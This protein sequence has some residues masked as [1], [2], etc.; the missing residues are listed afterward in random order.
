[1]N[2]LLWVLAALL[3][4]VFAAAGGMKLLASR[5]RLMS[6][7]MGYV[8]DF[9][10]GT[11]KTIGVLELLAAVALVAPPLVG[12]APWLTPLAALGLVLLMVGAVLTHRRRHE[13]WLVPAVLGLLALVV[14]WGRSVPAP[15]TGS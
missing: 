6:A 8:E 13:P 11:I 4:C 1:M 2:A 3:A 9:S 5:H 15:F 14:A 10:T 12:I 7:G